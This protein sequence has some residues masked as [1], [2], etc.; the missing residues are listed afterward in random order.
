MGL[1]IKKNGD[2]EWL[3]S[4]GQLHRIDGPAIEYSNGDKWWYINGKKHREDGP[5]IELSDGTKYWYQNGKLHRLDGP[6]CVDIAGDNGWWTE[7]ERYTEE[8]FMTAKHTITIDGKEVEIS[9]ES[10]QKIKNEIV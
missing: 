6:A 5:A 3:N 1:E 4:K 9:L 10:Y 7:G 8:E 2:R